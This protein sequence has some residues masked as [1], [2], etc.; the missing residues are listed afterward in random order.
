MITAESKQ[1][2]DLAEA[3]LARPVQDAL[4][5]AVVLEAWVGEQSGRA[6]EI[7]P[8]LVRA[9]EQ[10]AEAAPGASHRTRQTGA[11]ADGMGLVIAVLLVATWASPIADALGAAVW[12]GALVLALPVAL[13][14]EWM[15]LAR[16]GG[17]AELSFTRRGA[18]GAAVL[19]LIVGAA[20]FLSGAQ[21]RLAAALVV[22]WVCGAALVKLRLLSAYLVLLAVSSGLMHAGVEAEL[23]I[24]SA[25]LTSFSI[26][27]WA[28]LTRRTADDRAGAPSRALGWAA[29]GAGL[30]LML[31]ADRSIGWGFNG[32]VPALALIPSAAGSLWAAHHLSRIYWAMPDS[33]EGVGYVTSDRINLRGEATR[34]LGGAVIRM[35]VAVTILSV[36]CAMLGRWTDGTISTG[37]FAAFAA[38]G[39]A[40]LFVTLLASIRRSH[41]A[42]LAVASGLIVELLLRRWLGEPPPGTYL[43]SASLLAALLAA[44]RIVFLFSRPGRALATGLWI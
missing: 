2:R 21:G 8:E 38:F 40:S 15:L 42:A 22:T 33:L 32:S 1:A 39:L 3:R 4:E 23:V 5:A 31:V 14:L 9:P 44:T 27:L 30:G 28:V 43:L 29:I 41:L 17:G 35:A 7:G 12:N 6:L 26:A 18:S 11:L 13:A 34:I 37:L 36:L 25:A 16:H 20:L 10:P 19:L 24:W